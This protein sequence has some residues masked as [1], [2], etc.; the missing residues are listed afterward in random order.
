MLPYG[1]QSVDEHDVA[2]VVEVLGSDW[3]TTGPW[4]RAF[5]SASSPPWPARRVPSA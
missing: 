3:L 2:A 4:V 1:R 5:E